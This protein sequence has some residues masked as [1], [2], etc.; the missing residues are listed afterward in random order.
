MRTP[1]K[2]QVCSAFL[3][4]ALLL[5]SG[6]SNPSSQNLASL[7][8]T[9]TPSTLSVGGASVLKA[10]AHLT[11]G[12]TQDVTSGTQWTLSNTALATMSNGALNAK[13]PGTLTVQ[14]AYVEATPAGTS[15]ASAT[16]TPQNL[17][18][19]TQVTITAAGTSNTPSITW[20]APVAISYGT[21]LGSTQLNAQANVPGTFAYTPAAGTV[22]T[23]GTQTL[24]AVFTPSD[25]T[26]Y[27]AA[28]ATVQLTVTQATPV[29][30]WAALA[31]VPAGTALG[32]AQLDATANVPGA[33]TYNPAAGTVPQAGTL[34]L[35]ATF[36]PTDTTDYSSA[37]GQNTLVVGSSGPVGGPIGPP[38][39]GCGGPTINVNS[40]MSESTIQSTIASAPTCALVVFAAGTYNIASPLTIPCLNQVTITGPAA[41][42]ATAILSSTYSNNAIM[43]VKSCSSAN[44]IEY[45]GFNGNRPSGG[46]GGGIYVSPNTSNLTITRNT[47]HGNQGVP[48]S[49]GALA[50]GLIWLDGDQTTNDSNISVTWNQLGATGDCSSI[51]S[52]DDDEGAYCEGIGVHSGLTN[53]T[54]SNNAVYYQEEGIKVWEP[55]PIANSTFNNNDLSNIHRIGFEAQTNGPSM[56]ANYNSYHDPFVPY[57]YTFGLSMSNGATN[58]TIS[59]DNVIVAN[60]A[61]VQGE[62][63]AMAL[64]AWGSGSTYNNN[65][66]QG[67]WGNGIDYGPNGSFTIKN[68]VICGSD[69]A[70]ANTFIVSERTP[71]Y[72]P[73]ESGN[74]TG[75]NCSSMPSNA[76]TISPAAAAVSFPQTVTLSDTGTNTS[77]YYTT[78]GFHPGPGIGYNSALYWSIFDSIRRYG[79][80][81]WYVGI[82]RQS[83]KLS[84]RLRLCT[85]WCGECKL[86][87]RFGGQ[88]GGQSRFFRRRKRGIRGRRSRI[89][90]GGERSRQ[91][92]P[93]VSGNCSL[94]TCG[95]HREQNP[96]ESHRKLRRWVHQGRHRGLYLDFL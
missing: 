38:V 32:S 8:V 14:A 75:A 89:C 43:S 94:S 50:M 71:K 11:D 17:S 61:P 5:I 18:A 70:S 10:V 46:G 19:S 88:A 62:Y 1:P 30:T 49:G 57:F 58:P 53:S 55:M 69:M 68:N 96:V 76:P 83:P 42:P 80:R 6:C 16:T 65:L 78:D 12:T 41:T 59:N 29:I 66:I 95:G 63:I 26:T 79:E 34:Q 86:C 36:T 47:L 44:T 54:V 74:T 31:P 52:I 15:P 60:V 82:G 64:E 7:T 87:R 73:Q 3:C 77:I 27:S 37:T 9:A 21:A 72:A 20:S 23:A 13:A 22:L 84:L 85:E 40:G 39:K 28:T 92:S 93:G 2:P 81:G 45:L 25:T 35:T 67:Y 51:M 91:R 90:T 24:S 56:T 4:G 48:G 33:F